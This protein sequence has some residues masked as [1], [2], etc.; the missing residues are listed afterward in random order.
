M[1]SHMKFPRIF[2]VVIVLAMLVLCAGCTLPGAEEVIVRE[3]PTTYVPDVSVNP[4]GD[5]E[6]IPTAAPTTGIVREV[7]TPVPTS[8]GTPATAPES[9]LS[10]ETRY[11]L[12]MNDT[13]TYNQNTRLFDL[14][15][16]GVPFIFYFS[17]DPGY[18][19][20][21]YLIKDGTSSNSYYYW[22]EEKGEYVSQRGSDTA[23]VRERTT[24]VINPNSKFTIDIVR[25]YDDPEEYKAAIAANGGVDRL[26]REKLL[27]ED[28]G[29]IVKKEGYAHGYSSEVE[30]EIKLFQ[31]GHYRLVVYGNSITTQIMML[32]PE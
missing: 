15:I 32:S 9:V 4:E 7:T 12:L 23:N 2:F 11:H 29:I 25:I 10:N 27:Y 1:I 28:N 3:D 17:F 13:Q 21:Q 24:T 14:D 6:T 31:P 18:I 30:K 8:T 19:T 22:N 20:K 16:K 26:T 5:Y